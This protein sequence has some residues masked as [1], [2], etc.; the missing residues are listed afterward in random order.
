ML[1]VFLPAIGAVTLLVGAQ[2]AMADTPFASSTPEPDYYLDDGQYRPALPGETSTWDRGESMLTED[3]ETRYFI[4]DST[5]Q[6]H[7]V[8][9]SEPQATLREE[10]R[11]M[12]LAEHRALWR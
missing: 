10:R 2:A 3:D 11:T 12:G 4:P 7:P 1:R 5:D 8:Q 9:P 6:A